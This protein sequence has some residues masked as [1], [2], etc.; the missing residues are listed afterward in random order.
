MPIS[1]LGYSTCR[2][3]TLYVICRQRAQK[4]LIVRQ[5]LFSCFRCNFNCK[6]LCQIFSR[7]IYRTSHA[8]PLPFVCICS[9]AMTTAIQQ[10]VSSDTQ[11]LQM[12]LNARQ[13]DPAQAIGLAIQRELKRL[14]LACTN[15]TLQ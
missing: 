2:S 14:D 9:S 13:L 6:Q 15:I 5:R 10:P 12:H 7:Q 3:E 8:N 11:F 1:L 4:I